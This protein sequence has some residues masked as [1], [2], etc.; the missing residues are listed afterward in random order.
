[1][2][3]KKV[4]IIVA[5]SLI[6]LFVLATG[7]FATLYF[8]TDIFK[9]NEQIFWKYFSEN[10]QI[11]SI[12]SNEN[13]EEQ[14]NLKEQNSYT[15]TGNLVLS[16]QIGVSDPVEI[17]VATSS[18]HDKNTGR[19]YADATLKKAD[20]D[21]LKVSYINSNNVYSIKCEEI[22]QYY[23]G[24]RNENLKE[25]FKKW[26]LS[27]QQVANI[28]DSIDFSSFSSMKELISEEEKQHI[29]ETYSNIIMQTIPQESYKES[30]KET[31]T[32]NGTNY[33]ANKHTL[34]IEATT[35]KQIITNILTTLKNDNT[36]L[37]IINK[38]I[39]TI[40]Y[41]SNQFTDT[42][43]FGDDVNGGMNNNYNENST[44][45]D[46][47]SN[48][49]EGNIGSIDAATIVDNLLEKMN[50]ETEM[51]P[52][53]ISVYEQNGKTIRTVL[54]DADGQ[55][56]MI[57]LE[58]NQFTL[59]IPTINS[60]NN[61]SEEVETIYTPITFAKTSN[62]D[63]TNSITITNTEGE[64]I[65]ILVTMGKVQNG[66]ANNSYSITSNTISNDAE[67]TLELSYN[68]QIATTNQPEEIME[69]KDDNSVIVNNYPLDQ[70]TTFFK[71][72][73]GKAQQVFNN[74][75]QELQSEIAALNTLYGSTATT[76]EKI[77]VTENL[78]NGE[79]YTTDYYNNEGALNNV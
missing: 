56:V 63:V 38:Y 28:P 15:T 78:E 68:T 24:F 20:K 26:G 42:A 12:L 67:T 19:T 50:E 14:T 3:N 45:S 71:G 18:I 77:Q 52:I 29:K 39:N 7:T 59:S 4:V 31:I 32:I 2:K 76:N 30:E 33:E 8:A 27:D 9:T 54:E 62:K 65:T 49:N 34:E 40:S 23:I 53:I 46:I 16:T 66:T 22:S 25:L 75:V 21:L 64:T 55:N 5:I 48:I 69:L 36:T 1:M 51:E 72:I 11:T 73:S 79:L 41:A 47:S 13:I 6:V 44:N 61:L 58:K 60:Q 35:T 70:L 57:D 74:V 43:I 37:E 10:S 17:N